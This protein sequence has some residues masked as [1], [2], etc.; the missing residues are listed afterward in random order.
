MGKGIAE[1]TINLEQILIIAS[2]SGEDVIPSQ[3]LELVITT[4]AKIKKYL[5][6]INKVISNDSSV[7]EL[8]I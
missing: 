3:P 8:L 7:I 4:T 5:A 6:A 2:S 1:N